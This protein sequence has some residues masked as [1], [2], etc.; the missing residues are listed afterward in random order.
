VVGGGLAV[1]GF[2][3]D[4]LAPDEFGVHPDGHLVAVG[5]HLDEH[6]AGIQGEDGRV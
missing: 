1:L 4:G 3:F 6:D 5:Y 2:V